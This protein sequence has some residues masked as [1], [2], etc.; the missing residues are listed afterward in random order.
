MS[1]D[2][3]PDLREALERQRAARLRLERQIEWLRNRLTCVECGAASEEQ[4]RGW[5]TYLT[6]DDK[7]AHY[8]P[9]CSQ[10]EFAD[11]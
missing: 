6:D 2:A 9:D 3:R 10:E 5:R 11:A 4:A 1:E 7:P 8:C